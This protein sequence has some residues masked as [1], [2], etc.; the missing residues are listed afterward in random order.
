MTVWVLSSIFSQEM[1]F[2]RVGR[3]LLLSLVTPIRSA[4]EMAFIM[5]SSVKD[6]VVNPGV[7]IQPCIGRV[8]EVC[9]RNGNKTNLFTG[10]TD[11]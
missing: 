3:F 10:G 1:V 4:A 5:S 11:A 2:L 8:L 9:Y 6:F 7:L